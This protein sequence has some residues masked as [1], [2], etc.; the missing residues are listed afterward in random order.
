M[1]DFIE[2][3]Y[4]TS[5]TGIGLDS[6][7]FPKPLLHRTARL[8]LIRTHLLPPLDELRLSAASVHKFSIL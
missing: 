4:L 1:C 3:K 7:V 8:E 5:H 6:H 2:E